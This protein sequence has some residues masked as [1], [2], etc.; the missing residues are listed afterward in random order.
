MRKLSPAAWLLS[1]TTSLSL[2]IGE[3]PEAEVSKKIVKDS[4]L[5]QFT[6]CHINSGGVILFPISPV[7]P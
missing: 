3:G 7:I 2:A 4:M 1:S 6:N 5:H